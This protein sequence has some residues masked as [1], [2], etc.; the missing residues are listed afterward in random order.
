LKRLSI[1][2]KRFLVPDP[3]GDGGNDDAFELAMHVD[4]CGEYGS[5]LTL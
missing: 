3:L 5:D 1:F 4:D 2:L